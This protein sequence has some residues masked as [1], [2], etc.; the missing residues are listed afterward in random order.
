MKPFLFILAVA[1]LIFMS[2]CKPDSQ[3][4]AAEDAA[5]KIFE[6]QG[7]LREVSPDHRTATIQ[8]QKI[9]GYMPA[10]T[11]PFNVKMP[12]ELVGIEIGADIT[13]KLVVRTNEHW[14]EDIRFLALRIENIPN[15]RFVSPVNVPT[16]KSGEVL[17]DGELLGENGEPIRFRN[18]RGKALAFTFFFSRCPLPEYCPRMASNFLKTREAL[19]A[20][21]NAPTNWQFLSV[22]FDSG[23]DN[24]DVLTAYGN[25][26]RGGTNTD[27]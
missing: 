17:P 20:D 2:G 19:L 16:L 27:R 3:P 1:T 8:H 24:P 23:W 5:V 10:M 15:N 7:I 14:I 12:Q 9:P 13:F 21:A 4:N 22:S 25:Y 26:A 18:F 6:V 11:M